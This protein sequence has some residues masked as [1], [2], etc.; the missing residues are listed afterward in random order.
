MISDGVL[1]PERAQALDREQPVTCSFL[2]GSPELY[3]WANAN[4]RLLMRRPDV[5]NDPA[6]IEA[7][8]AMTAIN[9]AIQIDLYAQANATYVNGRIYS[10]FGGQPDFVAGALHS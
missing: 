4:P 5:V 7:R 8:G 1:Q 10:G 3:E 2:F 6:R 9:A